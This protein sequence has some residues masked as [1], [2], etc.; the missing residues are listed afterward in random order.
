MCGISGIRGRHGRA[1]VERMTAS[2]LHRGPDS[3]GFYEDEHCVLG[4]RRLRI[5]DIDG[6]EQPL[7]NE[8]RSVVLICNGEIY[9]YK[10]LREQLQQRHHVFST[11]GD[12]EVILHLFE[13]YG[14][15][16]VRYLRGMF[17]F[18]IWDIEREK[19]FIARD[20]LGIK[21]LYFAKTP[22]KFIFASEIRAILAS[23]DVQPRIDELAIVRFTSYPA[24]PAPLTIFS[25]IC[26]VLPG[27]SITVSAAGVVQKE[28]WDIDFAVA[29]TSLIPDEEAVD[30]VRKQLEDAVQVRLMSDVPL[31]AFLS[32]GIDSSA[33]VA[34]M[35]AR[36]R[37]P[38]R[39]FSI[40]FTGSEKSFE[41]FDDASFASRVAQYLKTDHNEEII[42]GS[43]VLHHLVD[44]VWAMDQP[45][46]DAIQYYLVSKCAARSVTVALS[47]TGG[48]EVFGGY[49]WFKELLTINSLHNYL[50][51]ISPSVA[52][53]LLEFLLR[54]R[55]ELALSPLRRRIETL[56]RGRDGF[57]QM[58][59]LNRRLYRGDDFFYIFNPDFIVKILDYPIEKN[60]EISYYA[61]RCDGL[62]PIAQTSY[63][64]IKTDLTNL[65]VRD[66]DAVSMAHSLEV[67][68]PMLDHHLVESAARITSH[69]KLHDTTEKYVL[70]KAMK[71]YLPGS[72]LNRTKKGFIFPMSQ[73]MRKELRPV[74]EDCLS[75]E[76]V[77]KRG[78]FNVNET[79]RLKDEFFAGKQ[80]FFRIWN[81]V[82]LE[83]WMRI[84]ID[85]P[86]GWER[87]TCG[88]RDFIR[89]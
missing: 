72:I 48:D 51:L 79:L 69:M 16:C 29:Q 54:N 10:Q 63:L 84:V 44:A 22:G 32:G 5:I 18:A 35:A 59:R 37:I 31:G 86:A 8:D 40:R 13:E 4:M 55:S 60:D 43:D 23:G 71:H 50:S 3:D 2:L 39:T 24:V 41:W 75:R 53:R 70:R 57:H 38:V 9:N 30:V 56:L 21:T 74:V 46:G 52:R 81:Q 27:H 61:P 28:Y 64:Q 15:D 34:I 25:E 83:L 62:D 6:S 58:Y 66:Q 89:S 76:S 49:E 47:G 68:L 42:T 45:S 87:P 85:R 36:S 88:I 7:Y 80:P 67:R 17:A 11:H 20:R 19:L 14:E 77:L 82:V 33:I 1:A 78:I 26:A 65:L 73:W 12:A